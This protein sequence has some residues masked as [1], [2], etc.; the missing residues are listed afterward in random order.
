MCRWCMRSGGGTVR[1]G[2]LAVDCQVSAQL[3]E[4][5]LVDFQALAVSLCTGNRDN[6]CS[7]CDLCR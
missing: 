7:T 1:G 5:G 2:R 4:P 6:L 3:S